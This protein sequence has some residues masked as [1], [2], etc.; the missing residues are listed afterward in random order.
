MTKLTAINT[1]QRKID[2]YCLQRLNPIFSGDDAEALKA[3]MRRF[4][5]RRCGPP[6]TNGK[7]DWPIVSRL[8]G[9]D[10]DLLAKHHRAIEPGF[11]A[12]FRWGRDGSLP[13]AD[14]S[15]PRSRRV[16][17]ARKSSVGGRVDRG[18]NDFRLDALTSSP[19]APTEATACSQ[20]RAGAGVACVRRST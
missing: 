9:V 5:E 8:T 7:T 20:S 12:S 19:H 3:Y 14:R 6:R 4:I 2:A 10:A 1:F 13:E 18:G 17:A 11:D 15:V 16:A